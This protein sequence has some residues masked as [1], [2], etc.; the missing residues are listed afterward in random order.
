MP[1]RVRRNHVPLLAVRLVIVLILLAVCSLLIACSTTGALPPDPKQIEAGIKI[2]ATAVELHTGKYALAKGE[3]RK[4]ELAALVAA[5]KQIR[6]AGL[7]LHAGH[8]LNYQ[9]AQAVAD[10][11]EIEELNIGHSIVSRA[12]VVGIEQA[13]REMRALVDGAR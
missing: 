5:G 9:N 7:R 10:I 4:Q 11:P 12:I 3:K 8:G 2:G 1:A 13:V 6:D